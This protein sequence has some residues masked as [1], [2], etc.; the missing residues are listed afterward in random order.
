MENIAYCIVRE[1]LEEVCNLWHDAPTVLHTSLLP[2]IC[3]VSFHT[4]LM[5]HL[6]PQHPEATE[7]SP[8]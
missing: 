3:L 5:V 8:V 6:K 7:T 2:A 1:S 4:F